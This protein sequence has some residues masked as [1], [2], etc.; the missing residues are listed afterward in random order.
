MQI[1]SQ[2]SSHSVS[3]VR[4]AAFP[5]LEGLRIPWFRGLEVGVLSCLEAGRLRASQGELLKAAGF[6]LFS[7]LWMGVSPARV[8]Y[9]TCVQW[10]WRPGEGVRRLGLDLQ[11]IVNSLSAIGIKPLPLRRQ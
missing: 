9:T 4:N 6:F 8:C 11:M 2:G 7:C 5:R 3:P 1:R 10:P